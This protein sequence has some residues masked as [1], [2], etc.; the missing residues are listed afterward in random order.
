MWL[1]C[2]SCI[3]C[4]APV[5]PVHPVGW[6]RVW[7]PLGSANSAGK[8]QESWDRA[9][10]WMNLIHPGGP[11]DWQPTWVAALRSDFFMLSLLD[12]KTWAL[13]L[14]L[15]VFYK[16]R[17]Q[18]GLFSCINAL[19]ITL[20]TCSCSSPAQWV[21]NYFPHSRQPPKKASRVSPS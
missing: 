4:M 15:K 18:N 16:S 7:I 9:G 17:D 6:V 2:L 11:G 1:T 14:A 13:L 5:L 12:R 3:L 19:T 8:E 21:L 20:W 10:W